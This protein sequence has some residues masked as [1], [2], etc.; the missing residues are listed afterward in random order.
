[1][2]HFKNQVCFKCLD[3]I[4]ILALTTAEQLDMRMVEKEPNCHN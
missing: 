2:Q 4:L 1:M 3:A